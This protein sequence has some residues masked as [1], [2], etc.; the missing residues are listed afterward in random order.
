MRRLALFSHHGAASSR[1]T[2]A[3][4]ARAAA[5]TRNRTRLVPAAQQAVKLPCARGP[6]TREH[7]TAPPI[8]HHR[9]SKSLP[10]P[11]TPGTHPP[12]LI[13][14]VEGAQLAGGDPRQHRARAVRIQPAP[15]RLA[16]RAVVQP[17]AALVHNLGCDTEGWRAECRAQL[18]QMPRR[19]EPGRRGGR[20]P[21]SVAGGRGEFGSGLS[22]VKRRALPRAT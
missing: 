9:P 12:D 14:Q 8:K 3:P 10:G 15:Q 6:R 21:Q 11:G 1:V 13:V 19:K 17:G 22:Q 16:P 20:S 18:C 2:K 7:K 5:G 4:Q